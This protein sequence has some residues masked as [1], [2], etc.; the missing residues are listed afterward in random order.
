MLV[1]RKGRNQHLSTIMNPT[2]FEMSGQGVLNY[3]DDVLVYAAT[4]EEHL[5][6]LDSV[7]ARLLQQK[8]Y[9]KLAKCKLAAQSIVYLEYRAG[10]ARIRPSTPLQHLLKH[11]A[12][13]QWTAAHSSAVQALEDR[14]IHSTNLSL[15]DLTKPFILRTDASGA[16]IGAVLEQDGKP[17]GFL[18]KRVSDAQMRYSTYDHE[19]LAIVRALE[20]WQHFLIAAEVTVYADQQAL[21]Y[22]TK[23]P[24]DRRIRGRLARWVDLLADVQ[25]PFH[26]Q[27]LSN[28]AFLPVF[29]QSLLC[30]LP[31]LYELKSGTVSDSKLNPIPTVA[32]PADLHLPCCMTTCKRHRSLP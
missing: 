23:L 18:S 30:E 13:F 24:C 17:L 14:L 5:R 31:S 11:K 16:A 28:Q 3:M 19:L 20:R 6:L 32:P 26:R 10:A 7:L 25:L 1:P 9:S 21:Q 27:P 22:L 15:P 8:A 2:F 12:S 4:F 29:R